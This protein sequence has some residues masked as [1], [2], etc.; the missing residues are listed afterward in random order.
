[1]QSSNTT[2]MVQH[3]SVD[4]K[5]SDVC[6][7]FTFLAADKQRLHSE[8]DIECHSDQSFEALGSAEDTVPGSKDADGGDEELESILDCKFLSSPRVLSY[9]PCPQTT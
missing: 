6:S 7:L 4:S 1:M 2:T 5:V 8:E 9:Y 3:N